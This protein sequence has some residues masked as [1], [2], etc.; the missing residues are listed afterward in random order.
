MWTIWREKNRRAFEDEEKL[1]Q[2]I[3]NIFLRNLFEYCTTL[4]GGGGGGC[5]CCSIVDFLDLLDVHL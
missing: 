4:F 5:S 1:P 3:K 2:D